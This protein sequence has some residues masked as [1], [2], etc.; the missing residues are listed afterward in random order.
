MRREAE[1]SLFGHAIGTY[2]LT[3]SQQACVGGQKIKFTIEG[4]DRLFQ[5]M[6]TSYGA[7]KLKKVIVEGVCLY[8]LI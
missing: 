1:T 3:M 6:A 7:V 8:C 4:P 2:A 5:K